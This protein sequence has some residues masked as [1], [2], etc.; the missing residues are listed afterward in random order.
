MCEGN[1][2]RVEDEDGGVECPSSHITIDGEDFNSYE[3]IDVDGSCRGD[4]FSVTIRCM[5][6]GAVIEVA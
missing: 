1:V 3:L 2:Y 5:K 4:I 6:C